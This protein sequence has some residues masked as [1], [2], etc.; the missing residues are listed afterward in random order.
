MTK[1]FLGLANLAIAASLLSTGARAEPLAAAGDIDAVKVLNDM[2]IIAERG[3]AAKLPFAIRL[4]RVQEDGECDGAP[5]SCP[6]QDVYVAVSSFDEYPD[7]KLYRLPRAYGWQFKDWVALP[8][9]DTPDQ[10]YVFTMERQVPAAD[11]SAGWWSTELY[12]VKVN[13]HD[14]ALERIPQ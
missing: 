4:L 11:T 7:R 6:V 14:A 9:S 3:G 5:Q 8:K 1:H 2:E 13:D 12:R 10:Y